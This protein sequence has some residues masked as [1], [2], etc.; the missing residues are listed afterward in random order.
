MD[1]LL[2]GREDPVK[3]ALNAVK[4]VPPNPIYRGMS[5]CPQHKALW[6]QTIPEFLR[7]RTERAKVSL[8]SSYS[9]DS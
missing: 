2:T 1:N 7:N 5:D 9:L 6:D 8:V 4:N 3:P